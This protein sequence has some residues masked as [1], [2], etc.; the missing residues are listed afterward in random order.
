MTVWNN[1]FKYEKRE[2][3]TEIKSWYGLGISTKLHHITNQPD[4][5]TDLSIYMK[6]ICHLVCW[7]RYTG[8]I[9]QKKSESV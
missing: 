2:Y 6:I 8:R 1:A 3:V 5:N 4:E 7:R 9:S